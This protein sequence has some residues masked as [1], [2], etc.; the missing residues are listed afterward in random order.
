MAELR[1]VFFRFEEVSGPKTLDTD[2]NILQIGFINYSSGVTVLINGGSL[3]PVPAIASDL[4]NVAN[5]IFWLP[6]HEGERDAT[7]YKIVFL[8]SPLAKRRLVV[9]YKILGDGN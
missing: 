8:G 7:Q 1:K 9:I 5:H 3:F 6:T 2:E 4:A